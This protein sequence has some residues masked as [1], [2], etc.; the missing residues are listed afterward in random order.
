MRRGVQFRTADIIERGARRET[1]AGPRSRAPD[2]RADSSRGTAARRRFHRTDAD[3]EAEGAVPEGGGLHAAW[4]KGSPFYFTAYGVDPAKSPNAKPVGYAFWT[5]DIVP[6]ERGYHGHIHML[7][8]MT[9]QGRIAGLIMDINTEPYGD[10]SINLPEFPTQFIGKSIRD[11]F[12]V[13]QDVDL[14]S[15]ATITVRAAA[16]EIRESSRIVA[17]RCSSQPTCADRFFTAAPGRSRLPSIRPT[18][19]FRGGGIR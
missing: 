11:R 2:G 18:D 14:T 19:Y 15:R 4:R 9:P 3:G 5:L 17:R 6:E 13:G 1:F 16:R 10:I 8:G 7:V 12:E